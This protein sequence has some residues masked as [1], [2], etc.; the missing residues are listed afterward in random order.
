LSGPAG[1]F[2]IPLERK[3]RRGAWSVQPD[4]HPKTERLLEPM[5]ACILQGRDVKMSKAVMKKFVG[6][7][8]AKASL[9]VHIDRDKKSLMWITMKRDW[10]R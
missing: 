1:Q 7:D 8:V 10:P 5:R 9:D 2:V 6:I 3:A 4:F